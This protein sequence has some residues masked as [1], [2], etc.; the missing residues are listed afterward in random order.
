[1][2][3]VIVIDTKKCRACKTCE[4]ECVL[5]H[6]GYKKILQAIKG[7]A[8]SRRLEVEELDGI[9]TPIQCA[10]CEAAP[11]VAACP[12]RAIYKE[13]KTGAIV[14]EQDLCVGCLACIIVCPY[15]IPQK[16]KNGRLIVK[17][18]LCFEELQSGNQPACV[19]GCPSKAIRFVEIAEVDLVKG[20]VKK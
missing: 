9:V 14:I 17:C 10:H 12:A 19:S 16:K 11:C 7:H 5:V 6:S 20:R 1:M 15:G 18:D 3:G 8:S 2:K 4:I 13:E